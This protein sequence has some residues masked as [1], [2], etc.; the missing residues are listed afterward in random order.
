MTPSGRSVVETLNDLIS[1]LE[2]A[3]GPDRELDAQISAAVRAIPDNAPWL[4]SF[5]DI[6]ATGNCV[7]AFNDKGES[8]A[9]WQ[10]Y[11]YTASV[12]AALMLV[13]DG[14][15]YMVTSE[16]KASIEPFA[17]VSSKTP[18][19]PDAR[20]LPSSIFNARARTAP[21]AL[22]IAALKARAIEQADSL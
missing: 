4:K 19:S 2:K 6:R 16:G 13:P 14:F 12:D 8:S 5:K 22:C 18:I 3:S 11:T 20:H 17:C 15:A 7:Q 10:P 1:R 21:L 9:N